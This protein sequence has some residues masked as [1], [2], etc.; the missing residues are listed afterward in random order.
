MH[1]RIWNGHRMYDT[2]HWREGKWLRKVKILRILPNQTMSLWRR[3]GTCRCKGSLWESRWI[4]GHPKGGYGYWL[5]G[6]SI[7]RVQNKSKA[8]LPVSLC[9]STEWFKTS[10]DGEFGLPTWLERRTRKDRMK[11]AL[12]TILQSVVLVWVE[13]H[14]SE[15]DCRVVTIRNVPTIS[16]GNVFVV[17]PPIRY[18]IP[19][20]SMAFISRF[21]VIIYRVR[22]YFW[23]R[24]WMRPP[25]SQLILW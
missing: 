15:G 7:R 8:H 5:E 16:T 22:W 20:Q 6:G 1:P 14:L 12:E 2:Q 18:L 13:R 21:E 23:W 10:V 24:S 17:P 9:R 4:G 25:V 19:G 11:A 3:I